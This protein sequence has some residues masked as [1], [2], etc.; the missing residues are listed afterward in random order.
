M[1]ELIEHVFCRI[2][3]LQAALAEKVGAE[4]PGRNNISPIPE[5]WMPTTNVV[6]ECILPSRIE[7]TNTK[8]K[9]SIAGSI[10]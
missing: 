9:K 10:E 4:S 6:F 5:E 1:F 3:P 7:Q 2:I 8:Y